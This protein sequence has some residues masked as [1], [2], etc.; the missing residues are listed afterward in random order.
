MRISTLLA[1]SAIALALPLAGCKKIESND[2]LANG[3]VNC[4]ATLFECEQARSEAFLADMMAE[5]IVIPVPKDP[6]GGY[7]HEQ[8]KR[9]YKAMYQGGQLYKITGDAKYKDYVR[10]MLLGYA[11]LYLTLG[12]HPA[13]KKQN[14]GKI[15]WQVLNDAVWLVNSIQGYEYIRDE[16]DEQDRKIIDDQ[17]FRPA[18]EFLS[19]ESQA[20]F[21]RIHNH[22]TW[23]TAGVGMTGY[24]LGDQDMVDRALY[25]SDKSGKVGFIKQTD[26]L[27]SPEGYYGEGPYYQRYALMPF[28]VFADAIERNDPD[29]KIFEHR[30]G[31][32]LKA[33]TTTVQLT[34]GGY[35]FP[36]NDAI[37]DKSL[38]TEELYHGI[39]I[40]YNKTGDPGLLSIAKGQGRTVLTPA[41]QKVSDDL[42]AG[43][44]EPF[45]FKSILLR[46]GPQGD[47][48]A[49]AVI[50]DGAGP[51]SSVM[52]IKNSSQ[53]LGHGHFD[54][55]GWQFYDNGNEIVRDYG[56]VRFLNIEAK[57]GGIYLPENTSWGKQSVAHNTLVVDGASHFEGK[58]SIAENFAPQQLY[59]SDAKGAQISS[60]MI[61]TAY[62]GVKMTRTMASVDVAGLEHPVI[63]DIFRADSA[64][65]H[66]YDLPLH[67]SGQI[68][69]LGFDTANNVTSRPV[70][71]SANGY[72][73]IW[74]DAI[75]SPNA[76]N[77]F[78]TWLL[79][80]RFYTY[81]MANAQNTQM[82]LA[83]SGAN[84]PNFNL[85]REP[86]IMARRNGQNTVF[87]SILERH[88]LTDGAAEQT[89]NSNSQIKSLS[90]ESI[91]GND[92]MIIETLA[93]AK[94][95]FAVSYDQ[96]SNKEHEV[97]FKNQ[98]IKWSG[99]A[100]SVPLSDGAA[101]GEN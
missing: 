51:K 31:I 66:Q 17:L 9:N 89:V 27:F 48:G 82:I 72:Q 19:V 25:G 11:E 96:D 92:I 22:A 55:L 13:K 23:A 101:E 50:R 29:K 63:V 21:D 93:G 8:H 40:A 10:E 71:G 20:T 41:G 83:E 77:A 81:R 61:D 45:P 94:T 62:D 95:A 46:D 35:F 34:Y 84:D 79:G 43:K 86:I 26:L 42:A 7:T 85:R 39:S 30:D 87:A 100:A 80:D 90:F 52:V 38:N 64:A 18:V 12:P 32:L 97:S 78:I 56:A 15:F 16:L 5:G 37:R 88:G 49:V 57:E 68:M 76:E 60:A 1:A 75:G 44:A 91:D 3:V 53:G 69:R 59:F 36:F 4:D 28:M 33:L 99:F 74:V 54:K 2:T 67:Y 58:L 65:A 98:T 14:Y 24:L 73:H 70:L 47:Q 6:G